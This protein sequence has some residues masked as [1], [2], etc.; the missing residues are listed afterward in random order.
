M[1]TGH[2][3]GAWLSFVSTWLIS[4]QDTRNVRDKESPVLYCMAAGLREMGVEL[5]LGNVIIIIIIIIWRSHG[6]E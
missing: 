4:A 2:V 6:S 5:A 1:E 3:G